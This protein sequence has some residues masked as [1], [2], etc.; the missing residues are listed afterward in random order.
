[1]RVTV[2]QQIRAPL[3]RVFAVFTD[4]EHFAGRIKGVKKSVVLSEVRA[5]PGLRWRETRD[6]FGKDADADK[7]L[8]A[9][10]APR[11]LRVESRVDGTN[12]ISTYAFAERDAGSTVVTWTHTSE[13]LTFGAKLMS[14]M[15]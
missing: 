2:S 8:T 15:L 12:Y 9:V 4:V 14:P 13:A 6:F 5:G 3:A 7:E 1:M 11:S 10:A